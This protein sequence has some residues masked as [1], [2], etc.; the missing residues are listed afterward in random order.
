MVELEQ[1]GSSGTQSLVVPNTAGEFEH[2]DP[3]AAAY[4]IE[5][6]WASV[7]RL[8]LELEGCLHSLVHSE[9]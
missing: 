5:G 7:E 3:I 9:A 8:L 1:N 6:P 2:M 4:C